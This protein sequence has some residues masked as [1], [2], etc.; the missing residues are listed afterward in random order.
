MQ[1]AQPRGDYDY[2]QEEV[3]TAGGPRLT[4]SRQVALQK[5]RLSKNKGGMSSGTK[6]RNGGLR[7]DRL[8]GSNQYII[9][10]P[11]VDGVYGGPRPHDHERSNSF[12][13][14]LG[15]SYLPGDDGEGGGLLL[16]EDD[17]NGFLGNRPRSDT[18]L[19]ISS[20]GL[21]GL[22]ES[23]GVVSG[24]QGKVAGRTRRGSE[25]WDL[26]TSGQYSALL[27]QDVFDNE[28]P[29]PSFASDFPTNWAMKGANGKGSYSAATSSSG[30]N[31]MNNNNQINSSSN[32]SSANKGYAQPPQA[33]QQEEEV[34]TRKRRLS[35][36]AIEE[37]VRSGVG[38]QVSLAAINAEHTDI[39]N[40][41]GE[42]LV[43]QVETRRSR[44]DTVE[45]L[46][47]YGGN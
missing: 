43:D 32:P 12:S 36:T 39:G 31:N 3:T 29:P 47:S 17:D 35:E 46:Q 42:H 28:L 34:F 4:S 41:M 23:L 37:P 14:L 21:A 5:N 26:L 27:T 9:S 19:S 18:L 1:H 15:G 6:S 40:V 38:K 20:V 22:G 24:K 33:L 11:S 7:N 44:R 30:S 8:Y 25:E 2:Y 16:G 10:D 13:S 45:L